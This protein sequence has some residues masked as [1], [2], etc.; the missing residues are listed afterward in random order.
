MSGTIFLT[1]DPAFY[2]NVLEVMEYFPDFN[3]RQPSPKRSPEGKKYSVDYRVGRNITGHQQRA[4][5]IWWAIETCGKRGGLGLNIGSAC[6]HIP[7]CITTEA[8]ATDNHPDY[9]GAYWPAMV[10][11]GED[12]SVFGDKAFDLILAN[13]VIEHVPGDIV[14]ML[15]QHWLRVLK[16]GGRIAAVL[17]DNAHGDVMAIDKSHVHAWSAAE[18][19]AQVLDQVMDL[20]ELTEFDSFQNHFSFNFVLTKR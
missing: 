3:Y 16:P 1:L 4:F 10:V 17:P 15:R 2:A 19:K 7:W 14:G 11:K 12:L 9:G 8:Y 20:A 18:F 5:D 13:H 6:V